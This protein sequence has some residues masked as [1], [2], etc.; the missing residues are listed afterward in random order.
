MANKKVMVKNPV[1]KY[2]IKTF[3]AKYQIR[4][5]YAKF[6]ILPNIEYNYNHDQSFFDACEYWRWQI[7][8]KF[9]IFGVGISV[10][11]DNIHDY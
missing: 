7:S 1:T 11:K 10:Y 6:Y 3:F 8:L 2:K 4:D 5:T 9:L